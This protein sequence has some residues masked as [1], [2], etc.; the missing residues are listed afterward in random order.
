MP[1]HDPLWMNAT[2]G[3]HVVCGSLAFVLAPV[4]LITA[5]GGKAHR[6]WGKVYYYAMTGVA[7]SAI[8]MAAY[9]PLLFLALVAIFSF[10]NAWLAYRVLE[11][12]AAFKGERVVR[13]LDWAVATFTFVASA[14]LAWC[15]A[16]R[17]VLVQNLAIPAMIFGVLGM[18][19]AASAMWRYTRQP[20]EKMFWW[21]EHLRGMLASYIAAWTAFLVVTVDPVLHWGVVLWVLPTAIGVPAVAITTAYYKRKFAPRKSAPLPGAAV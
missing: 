21:Y 16:F 13:P 20:K 10:Y 6:R 1:H 3:L 8:L 17:P 14:L 11:Q 5:K 18:R 9:R 12:K 2:L 15:G 19:I 4:A 7:V